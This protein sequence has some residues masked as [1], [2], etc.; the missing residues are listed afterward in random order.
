MK[1]S[2]RGKVYRC[3]IAIVACSALVACALSYWP[4]RSAHAVAMPKDSGQEPLL[5]ANNDNTVLQRDS[6]GSYQNVAYYDSDSGL[7]LG[8]GADPRT[9]IYANVPINLFRRHVF[10]DFE[11]AAGL[12]PR[13]TFQ[14]S[15]TGSGESHMGVFRI[16]SGTTPAS[17]GELLLPNV[18][19]PAYAGQRIYFYLR[20]YPGGNLGLSFG[21]RS[22]SDPNVLIAFSR[23]DTLGPAGMGGEYIARTAS[24]SGRIEETPTGAGAAPGGDAVRRLFCINVTRSQD[25]T[26]G[27]S[28]EVEFYVGT[29]GGVLERK[30]IHTRHI[31]DVVD[32]GQTRHLVPFV[33]LTNNAAVEQQVDIDV[34]YGVLLR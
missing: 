24:G 31:P 25:Q 22:A 3:L 16:R 28:G 34:I 5:F 4:S 20:T 10:V 12:D 6:F 2:I 33:R 17:G 1:K 13:C 27:Q 9:T 19:A 32:A 26:N 23:A 15:G 18:S 8:P 30:A 14:N 11:E 21:L 7:F 29:E